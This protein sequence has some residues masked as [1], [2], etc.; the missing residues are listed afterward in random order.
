[1]G[2]TFKWW[3]DVGERIREAAEET[4]V[5][6]HLAG[7]GVSRNNN[8]KCGAFLKKNVFSDLLPFHDGEG[9]HKMGGS[10][11]S[12]AR[13]SSDDYLGKGNARCLI[14]CQVGNLTLDDVKNMKSIMSWH[15]R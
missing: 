13:P 1:L 8:N 14:T 3:R 12:L 10:A 15:L 7:W 5:G 9:H 2:F 6:G 11:Q 4:G